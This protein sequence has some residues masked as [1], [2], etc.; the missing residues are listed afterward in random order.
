MLLDDGVTAYYSERYACAYLRRP[1][2]NE[3]PEQVAWYPDTRSV[4]ARARLAK[5]FNVSALI[6]PD[7]NALTESLSRAF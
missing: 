4:S 1:A 7:A 5:L 3:T 2:D 6:V